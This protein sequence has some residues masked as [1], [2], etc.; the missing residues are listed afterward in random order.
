MRY[1]QSARLWL[2]G[3]K[4]VLS[5]GSQSCRETGRWSDTHSGASTWM[6]SPLVEGVMM[7]NCLWEWVV[8]YRT[9]C[10]GR[11][12]GDGSKNL[13]FFG[14]RKPGASLAK[15]YLSLDLS[16]FRSSL[17]WL[18]LILWFSMGIFSARLSDPFCEPPHSH[19]PQQAVC[20]SLSAHITAQ[21]GPFRGWFLSFFPTRQ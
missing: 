17:G 16:F 2:K 19:P 15:Y 1:T 10:Q 9:G 3:D 21:N 20:V 5:W 18:L 4:I 8:C 11:V 7:T 13:L 12:L 6:D 14:F